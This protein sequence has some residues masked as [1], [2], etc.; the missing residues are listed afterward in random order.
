[1]RATLQS[2]AKMQATI[3]QLQANISPLVE[4]LEEQMVKAKMT[5]LE[6]AEAIAAITRSAGKASTTID[7]K[8]FYDVV[9]E[10][11]FFACVT[12]GVT[13]AKTVLGQKEIDKISTKVPG[14]AGPQKL[15]IVL[16]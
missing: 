10:D 6:C 12:V 2:I 5:T 14:T 7:A 4:Q 9:D 11:D 3:V 1:M 8:K 13:K 16:K 15:S